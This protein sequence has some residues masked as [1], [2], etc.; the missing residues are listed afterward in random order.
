[1][2][3]KLAREAAMSLLFERELNQEP[4]YE[5]LEEMKDIL[6]TDSFIERHS[7][8][9]TSVIGAFEQHLEEVDEVISEFCTT[10]K[11]DRLGKVD[12]AILRLAVIELSY[13]DT[14]VKVVINE[15][16]EMA[17]K[18][19]SERSSVFVHGVLASVVKKLG[20]AAE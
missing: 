4:N 12:L 8:Y 17:K 14:P 6:K 18:Y 11:L 15:S 2:S 13:M 7:D 5:T 1:M 20:K 10:W 9:I 19:S 16:V 3:R